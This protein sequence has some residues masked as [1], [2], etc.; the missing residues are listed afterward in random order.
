[1]RKLD[2]FGGTPEQQIKENTCCVLCNITHTHICEPVCPHRKTDRRKEL[3]DLCSVSGWIS[4]LSGWSLRERTL[5]RRDPISR[6]RP[7]S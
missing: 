3:A 5:K 6:S 2:S 1:M 4:F 7:G